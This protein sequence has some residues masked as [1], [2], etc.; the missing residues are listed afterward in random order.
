M[1]PALADPLAYDQADRVDVGQWTLKN[2]DGQTDRFTYDILKS[3]YRGR[4]HSA[5]SYVRAKLR[6][7]DRPLDQAT[8]HRDVVA[9][10]LLL[11]PQAS[12]PLANPQRLWTEVDEDTRWEGETH[13][14]A[15]ATLWFPRGTLQHLAIRQVTA[16]AQAE[17][18]DKHMVAVH[19]VA[20]APGRIARP[21]DFHIHLLCTARTIT[22]SGLD[23]FAHDLFTDGC[24]TRCK[25]RWETWMKANAPS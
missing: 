5:L 25:D 2:P 15:A 1:S 13:L 16:F 12:D 10:H 14:L 9:H 8:P 4:K 22:G 19:L 24:Q 17:L 23:V 7:W 18:A 20:H 3:E 21:A 6:C 11:P